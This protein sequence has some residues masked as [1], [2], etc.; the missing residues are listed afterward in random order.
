MKKQS[1]DTPLFTIRDTTLAYALSLLIAL[2]MAGMSLAV[3]FFQSAIYPTEE[4][5][6]SFVAN[7]VVN[8]FIGLPI[9]LAS[10]ALSRRGKL[11]RTNSRYIMLEL[12]LIFVSFSTRSHNSCKVASGCAFTAAR[13]TASAVANLR[14]GPPAYGSG[15]HVPVRRFRPNQRSMLGSLTWY[16]LAAA[17]ILYSPLS[18]L[19]STR[20]RRS[21]EYAFIPLIMPSQH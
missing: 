13:I 11:S 8:L 20:S 12:D 7:D 1:T 3:L 6:Q 4:T 19:A 18:T 17:G 2:M 16:R 5:R 14:G 21:F 10:M 9:L 15:A